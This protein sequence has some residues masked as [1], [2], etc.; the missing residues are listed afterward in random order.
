MPVDAF[1]PLRRRLLAFAGIG[2]IVP[3]APL[4]AAVVKPGGP[5]AA[6][7]SAVRAWARSGRI[8]FE[9]LYG[10][11]ALPLGRAE[12]RWSHDGE[13]Y[14]MSSRARATGLLSAIDGLSYVQRSVGRIRAWGL[15]PA[16]FEVERGGRRRE[17]SEFDWDTGDVALYRDGQA[18]HANIRSGD[19]DVL[20]LW[21]QI[22]LAEPWA[23]EVSLTVV[24][25]KS[26]APSRL[27]YLP[28]EVV[29]VP[30]GRF[31]AR[32]LRAAALDG[33]LVLEVW[34]AK[35]R[36]DAPVRIRMADRK[37]EILDQRA[38]RVQLG[39]DAGA[40]ERGR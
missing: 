13:R 17:W 40:A 15:Q 12:H 22:G 35:E 16:S 30:A 18:R 27:D 37:G 20:T 10:R 25:G 26:A 28:D 31:D 14:Q 36:D 21:H 8:D 7:G 39:A 4:R 5:L 1:S 34:L 6:P 19:Q 2:M 11:M 23:G 9:V 32:H 38:L 24:T 33:S 3:A 29:E